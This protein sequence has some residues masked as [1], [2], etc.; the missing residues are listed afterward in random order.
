[1]VTPVDCSIVPERSADPV[2][3]RRLVRRDGAA[4]LTGCG[5]TEEDAR[6]AVAAVFG[7]EVVALPPAAAVREG[8][9]KDPK[10]FGPD[11]ALPLHTDGFAYGD[12]APDHFALVCVQ[13]GLSGGDSVLVDSHRLLDSLDD[14]LGTFLRTRV[15]DQAEPGMVAAPTS[16]PLAVVTA[17]GRL[18]VRGGAFRRPMA[19]D[20]DPD[21]TQRLLDRWSQAMEGQDAVA[22]RFLLAAGDVVVI[23]NYRALH[24]RRPYEGS[25]LMWRVWVWTTEGNGVPAGDLHSDTRYAAAG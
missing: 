12:L 18:A 17:G 25:R 9:D 21:G 23:D 24:G 11:V 8:G 1:M 10:P 2:E 20:P 13:P 6:A 3:V 14:E 7:A 4:I 16:T 19:D 5:P 22:R 15:V